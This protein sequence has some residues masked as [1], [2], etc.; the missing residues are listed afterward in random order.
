MF[1]AVSIATIAVKRGME[2]LEEARQRFK[3]ALGKHGLNVNEEQVTL[4]LKFN[5]PTVEAVSRTLERE[6]EHVINDIVTTRSYFTHK[7]NT[8]LQ[9]AIISMLSKLKVLD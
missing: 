2:G 1:E 3:D 7:S 5:V 4:M 9:A 6:S 8:K